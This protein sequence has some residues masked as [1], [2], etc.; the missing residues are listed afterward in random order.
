[1]Q[2]APQEISATNIDYVLFKEYRTYLLCLYPI[3]LQELTVSR[4]HHA[5]IS[6]DYHISQP[7]WV[8]P[9]H[10]QNPLLGDNLTVIKVQGVD[11]R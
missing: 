9:H 7:S 11:Y 2:N 3:P 1:M 5:V 10:H 4:S 8:Q 6:Q